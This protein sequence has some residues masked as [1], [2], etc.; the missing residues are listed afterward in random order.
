MST[1]EW[2]QLAG[3]SLLV[4]GAVPLMTKGFHVYISWVFSL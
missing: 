1:K 4:G 3:V 2:F